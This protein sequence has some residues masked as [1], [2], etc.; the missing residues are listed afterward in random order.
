MTKKREYID[1]K[2]LLARPPGQPDACQVSLLPTPEVGE[3][4]L[5]VVV[6][7]Q[8]GPPPD[9]IA[10]LAN[11]SITLRNMVKYGKGLANWL[12]PEGTI[13]D[14]FDQALKKAG[15]QGGVR[16]RLVIAD[17]G[18]KG[19][20][21]EYAYYD[22]LEGPDSMRGFLALDPR[23]SIVRHEPLPHPHPKPTPQEGTPT[24]LRMVVAAAAP[25]GQKQLDLDREVAIIQQALA[26]FEVD[27]LHIRPDPVLVKAT[28]LEVAEALQGPEP[29]FVFH[30]AGH[31][32]T[33]SESDPFTRGSQREAGYLFF[34]QDKAANSEARVRADDLARRL[35]MGDVRLAVMGACYSG[36]R[37]S[38][39]PWDSVAGAFTA[40]DIPAVVSMQFEVYDTHAIA[41]SRAFYGALAAG[42]SLDEAMTLARL[43][44]YEE[45]GSEPDARVNTEWGVPVLYSRLPDGMLLPALAAQE[46][47]TAGKIRNAIQQTAD[48]ISQT[49]R[50]IGIEAR[51]LEGS[52]QVDQRVKV[53][54]GELIG[55]KIG[56]LSGDVN[57]V[58]NLGEVSG[59]VAGLEIENL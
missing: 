6:S 44:M 40:R 59:N 33:V 39:Y 30:F 13:R 16:L 49:G 1:F 42:L 8:D 12:L 15:N 21:W 2:L 47:E 36:Y 18:L 17:H 28:P 3:T 55:M 22:S 48:L 25:Q 10:Y 54:D 50:V 51:S 26:A 29:P 32:T 23:I 57:I 52:F 4:T 19:L 27:G 45:T 53:V 41:F 24:N 37:S 58:Q 38:R 34:V 56:E 11:K 20:P 9:Q 5:P 14:L 31:G 46:T 7:A 43:S 35:Q